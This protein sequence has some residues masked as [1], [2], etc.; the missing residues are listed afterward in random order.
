[1]IVLL[2][3]TTR[4][5]TRLPLLCLRSLSQCVTWCVVE[6]MQANL[7]LA[8]NKP[9]SEVHPRRMQHR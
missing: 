1:M 3:R 8:L 9:F 5:S 4:L 6:G 2:V 7:S